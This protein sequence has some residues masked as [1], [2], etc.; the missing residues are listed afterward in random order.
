MGARVVLRP[1]SAD[2]GGGDDRDHLTTLQWTVAY[3]RR[4]GQAVIKFH[5]PLRAFLAVRY[6]DVCF[7]PEAYLSDPVAHGALVAESASNATLS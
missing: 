5:G 6:V 2:E 4:A 7:Q 3:D 1:R